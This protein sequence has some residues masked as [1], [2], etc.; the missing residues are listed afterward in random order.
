VMHFAAALF[1]CLLL[2]IP[3]HTW[4][5]LGTLLGAGALAGSIYSGGL[6]VQMIIRRRFKVDLSDRL[7]YAFL[8]L[9]GYVLALIAAALLFTQHPLSAEMIAAAVL[10]LLLAAIRNAWDMMVWIVIKTPSGG[11]PPP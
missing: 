6:V 4:H 1:A 5:T 2:T 7:F 10:I 8:P 3:T 11:A 9:V